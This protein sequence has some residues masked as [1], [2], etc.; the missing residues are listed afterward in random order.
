MKKGILYY[1]PNELRSRVPNFFTK[2]ESYAGLAL[3]YGWL[4]EDNSLVLLERK[5][6]TV[7]LPGDLRS[8][9]LK[10]QLEKAKDLTNHLWLLVEDWNE[11]IGNVEDDRLVNIHGGWTYGN[12][13]KALF[14][15]VEGLQ[16]GGPIPSKGRRD[17]STIIWTLFQTSQRLSLGSGRPVLPKWKATDRKSVAEAYSRAFP[18]LG[19]ERAKLLAKEFP[20]WI[21]LTKATVRDMQ[22]VSGIGPGLAQMLHDKLR[23]K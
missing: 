17:T 4:A 11:L 8:G 22:R 20:T 15:L 18:G 16:V 13:L 19:F 1:S 3:D 10:D 21:A 5:S 14:A 23:A 2:A 7:D 12:L 9:H 6:V